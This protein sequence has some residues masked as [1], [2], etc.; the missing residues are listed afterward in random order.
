M[1]SVSV[2]STL[3]VSEPVRSVSDVARLINTRSNK[4]TYARM[5]V[6]L[7]LG[8]V[9]LDAYDLTTLS[10]GIDDVVKEFQL[11]PFLTG[12]VTSSIMVGTIVGNLVGGWLT[13]KYGRY[14]VFMADMLFFVVSAIAAGLAPNVWVLIGARFL[15]GVGVGIDLPVAMSYLA[16]FSKFAGKANKAS[17]LAAWCPMWYAAS[18]VCF[19]LIFGLY[20]LLPKEHLDWLWRASLLFGAV[21]ALLIIAVRSKFMNESPLWAANQ[22][23]L[24]AAV[25]ILR[26]SYGIHAHEVAEEKITQTAPPKV[27]FK[28]LFQKPWRERTI[29]AGVMNI[30]ISFEYTAIAFFLP[31]ILAQFLG[32]G[33]FETISASLGLNALF[34]FTG[35]LLGMRLAWKYPSRHVAI[36]GFAIQF[37]ALIS[38]ALIGHPQ[39]LIGVVFA[40]LMLGVWLFAEGFGPGA[41]LM[42]YPALSYPTSIRAT[43]V[44]F[45]RALSGIG[46]AL[47]L[48][49]LPILQ[50]S[51]GTNMFWVVSLSAIIPIFFLLA[52]RHEPTRQ[53]IDDTT[54]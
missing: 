30:C 42:I 37:I 31:S 34:A 43:G 5:I 26:D 4:N 11:S 27:S 8:G 9:F 50:A 15:M 22:G 54:D 29:V 47:A 25:R 40:I 33:V 46:S 41:Q 39:A 10:Y 38:L 17:R 53:D 44:G 12:L 45:S 1:S 20:F 13:D 52:V 51:L 3:P 28:V 7:A 32:A 24:K 23:D 36:A 16:E 49:I 19:F 18:S 2:E 35:G 48:F 6:F 14:S 21:P